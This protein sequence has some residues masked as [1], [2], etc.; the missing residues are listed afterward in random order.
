MA[1]I[2]IEVDKHQVTLHTATS[3]IT[4]G[5]PSFGKKNQNKCGFSGQPH[6]MTRGYTSWVPLG[7]T[8]I[9]YKKGSQPFRDESQF[10][11]GH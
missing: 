3:A 1:A 5:Y 8:L 4:L 7:K 6:V 11:M 9:A 10:Y 2:K